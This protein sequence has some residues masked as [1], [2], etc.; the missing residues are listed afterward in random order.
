MATWQDARPVTICDRE[1]DR[2]VETAD[3]WLC[4][5]RLLSY[6]LELLVTSLIVACKCQLSCPSLTLNKES[7][8]ATSA[9]SKGPLYQLHQALYINSN[10]SSI[11]SPT[12]IIQLLNCGLTPIL[13][14]LNCDL[15]PRIQFLH[16]GLTPRIQLLNCG[17]TPPPTCSFWAGV[18]T[19][20]WRLMA[21]L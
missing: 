5:H 19:L 21:S 3:L 20:F 16:C 17:L 11:S 12:I 10:M 14:F 18:M 1:R 8:V 4:V 13:Q 9:V 7:S 15:P 6:K 2:S